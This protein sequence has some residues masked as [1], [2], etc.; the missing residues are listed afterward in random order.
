[1]ANLRVLY[2]ALHPLYAWRQLHQGDNYYRSS[3][4]D[5]VDGTVNLL[6]LKN[7]HRNFPASFH[8]TEGITN[9]SQTLYVHILL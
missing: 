4:Y 6:Y 3:F 5:R 8:F 1:M 7:L 2:L 9:C